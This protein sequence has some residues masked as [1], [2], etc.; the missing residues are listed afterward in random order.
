[1]ALMPLLKLIKIMKRE[2]FIKVVDKNP[3]FLQQ[4]LILYN[5]D[6][7]SL[8]IKGGRIDSN[9]DVAN[10]YFGW[11]FTLE[12]LN[13]CLFKICAV[14]QSNN[15]NVTNVNYTIKDPYWKGNVIT[16]A[17]AILEYNLTE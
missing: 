12:T 9:L 4:C 7:V 10:V 15:P 3:G 5:G 13:D 14:L 11:G 8:G 16:N 6:K 2:I 17:K 1:M